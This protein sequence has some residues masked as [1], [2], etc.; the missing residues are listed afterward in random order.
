MTKSSDARLLKRQKFVD[1]YLIHGN[2]TKAAIAAGYSKHTARTQGSK[3]LTKPDIKQ[4]VDAG[5]A[6]LAGIAEASQERVVKELARIAFV[7]IRKLLTP[8]GAMRRLD[9]IDDDT[10]AAIAGMEIEEEYADE[11]V[12]ANLEAQGHGGA[13]KRS[14]KDKVRVAVGR[15]AKFKMVSKHAALESLMSYHGMH[16]SSRV[17]DGANAVLFSFKDHTGKPLR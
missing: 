9:E 15:V 16:K 7:D 13:L 8:H 2:A 5:R 11:T 4:L 6:R 12:Q 1:A 10:A 3:L 17:V 14:R